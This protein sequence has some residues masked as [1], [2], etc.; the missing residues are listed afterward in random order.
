MEEDGIKENSYERIV[1]MINKYL[2]IRSQKI[3]LIPI[4]YWYLLDIE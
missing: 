1:R 2:S 4:A 3:G